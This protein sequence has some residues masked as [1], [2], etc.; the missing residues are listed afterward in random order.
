M[1]NARGVILVIFLAIAFVICVKFTRKYSRKSNLKWWKL[2]LELFVINFLFYISILQFGL[3]GVEFAK[4][5]ENVWLFEILLLLLIPTLYAIV[6]RL[7]I[8]LI[9]YRS[10]LLHCLVFN[11][12]YKIMIL[13]NVLYRL[14]P[15]IF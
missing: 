10:L 14:I 9:G 3:F 1:L 2:L 11:R 4:L 6:T 8:S 7:M 12:L 13:A 5:K 15:K